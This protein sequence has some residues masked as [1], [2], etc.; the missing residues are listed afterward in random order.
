MSNQEK[1]DLAQW[2]HLASK[3]L[4]GKPVE[5]LTWQTAEGIAVKPLYTQADLA[6]LDHL[7]GLPGFSPYCPGPAGI[8]R[9]LR[10]SC[11]RTKTRQT[12]KMI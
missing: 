3:E 11:K 7:D 5:D 4:R 6:G 8:H 12:I 9:G 1:P 10:A 2:A